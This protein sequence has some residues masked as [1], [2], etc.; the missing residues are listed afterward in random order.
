MDAEATN[1]VRFIW[2]PVPRR[3]ARRHSERRLISP[4]R[5]A[6]SASSRFFGERI[7]AVMGTFRPFGR[8]RLSWR[9]CRIARMVF[10]SAKSASRTL[11]RSP[12]FDGCHD[13]NMVTENAFRTHAFSRQSSSVPSP[14]TNRIFREPLLSAGAGTDGATITAGRS[15]A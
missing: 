2:N 3:T 1:D 7:S 15:G 9:I 8:C 5:P 6:R 12:G 14:C 10:V 13:E 11:R 4:P